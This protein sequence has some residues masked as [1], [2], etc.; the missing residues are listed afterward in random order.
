VG[1]LTGTIL[2]W[3]TGEARPEGPRAGGLLE[4]G[5]SVSS[6]QLEGLGSAVSSP[7]GL[8]GIAPATEGVSCILCH[9][10]ASPGTWYTLA[11]VCMILHVFIWGDLSVLGGHGSLGPRA[12]A[13]DE[14]MHI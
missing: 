8:R 14:I 10:I 9:Q 4:R 5:Q 1:A 13:P 7:S 11:A 3:G 6:H 2:E 12:D